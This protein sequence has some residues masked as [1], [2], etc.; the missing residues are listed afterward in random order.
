[1][2]GN[3]IVVVAALAL[4]GCHGG[5]EADDSPADRV[6]SVHARAVES[7]TFR[8]VVTATGEWRS[9]GDVVIEAPFAGVVDSLAAQLGDH[10]AAGQTLCLLVTSEARAGLRARQ[11]Q[12]SRADAERALEVARRD[13]VRVPLTA[14][15][16]GTVSRLAVATGGEVAAAEEIMALIPED[17]LVF[18]A[19]VTSADAARVRPG[20]RATVAGTD[21]SPRAAVVSKL[22]PLGNASDQST[23]VWLQPTSTASIPE[24]GRFG[25]ATIEVGAAR[26][27]PAVPD[28]AVVEDDL[29]GETRVAQVIASRAVWTRVTLGAGAD[30]WHEV[31]SPAL[32][33]GGLVITSGHR[34]LPESTRV[35]VAP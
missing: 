4:C 28:S 1:M 26:V 29:T 3:R 8:D 14:P 5:G 30:D 19:H 24:I 7:R 9:R 10:V 25:T 18:E 12:V 35:T 32:A 17:G 31:V 13:L 33:P 22:L 21:S 6:V 27:G 2:R 34:G 20:Q 23:L 11:A 15:R 16:A